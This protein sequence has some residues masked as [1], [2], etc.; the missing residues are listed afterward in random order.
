MKYRR[1]ALESRILAFALDALIA[2][3]FFI[4]PLPVIRSILSASYLLLRDVIMYEI[5][6]DKRWRNRSPGKRA[7]GLLV[8]VE[9]GTE[10]YKNLTRTVSLQ[11]NFVP[12]L[13]LIV[14]IIPLL[15][16][17]LAPIISILV[18]IIELLAALSHPEKKRLGDR[19]AKTI[20]IREIP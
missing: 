10:K 18:W 9:T 19:L 1:A 5:T 3:L 15:G 13:G 14:G 20:V 17:I 12:A 8:V 7:L 6:S 11:R 4:M 16:L 2:G